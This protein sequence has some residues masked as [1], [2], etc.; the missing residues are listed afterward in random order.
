MIYLD[1]MYYKLTVLFHYILNHSMNIL[2][3]K[4]KWFISQDKYIIS[5]VSTS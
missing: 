2:Y 1:T 5:F 4:Y 3:Q